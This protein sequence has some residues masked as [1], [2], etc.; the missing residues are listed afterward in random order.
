MD[1]AVFGNVGKAISIGK[2]AKLTMDGQIRV[3]DVAIFLDTQPGSKTLVT[4]SLT[5]DYRNST[6]PAPFPCNVMRSDGTYG[7]SYAIYLRKP[8]IIKGDAAN[9]PTY[10]FEEND[11]TASKIIW[12]PA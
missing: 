9:K 11:T 5:L 7:G 6:R 4:G 10:F 1:D 3:R 12:A 2:T 8:V